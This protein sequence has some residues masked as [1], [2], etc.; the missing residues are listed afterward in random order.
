MTENVIED[1]HVDNNYKAVG[2]GSQPAY[3]IDHPPLSVPASPSRCKSTSLIIQNAQLTSIKAQL[4]A[5]WKGQ[6]IKKTAGQIKSR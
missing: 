2:S 3:E 1:K 4:L 5:G 6:S